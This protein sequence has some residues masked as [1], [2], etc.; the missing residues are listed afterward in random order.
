MLAQPGLL[1]LFVVVIIVG[2]H[3]ELLIVLKSAVTLGVTQIVCV[4]ELMPHKFEPV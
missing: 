3:K 1:E 2:A 4:A